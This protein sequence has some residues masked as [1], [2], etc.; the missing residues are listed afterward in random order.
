M[1]S[2]VQGSCAIFAAL[3]RVSVCRMGGFGS[4]LFTPAMVSPAV[5]HRTVCDL[6]GTERPP[7]STCKR[8]VVLGGAC[9]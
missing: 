3:L 8:Q 7:N 2:T 6:G 5:K 1:D 4:F 9:T